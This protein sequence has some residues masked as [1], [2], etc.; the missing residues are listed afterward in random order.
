MRSSRDPSLPHVLPHVVR[1][2]EADERPWGG[3]ID[4]VDAIS[5]QKFDTRVGGAH[6][7]EGTQPDRRLRAMGGVVK[8]LAQCLAYEG[9]IG[10][11]LGLDDLGAV[12]PLNVEVGQST[13]RRPE[14]SD[15]LPVERASILLDEQCLRTTNEHSSTRLKVTREGGIDGLRWD[16]LSA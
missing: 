13:L 2:C 3:S 8:K 16:H 15:G 6:R 9:S 12:C 1:R 14:P 4:A 10:A 11:S 5:M 7:E